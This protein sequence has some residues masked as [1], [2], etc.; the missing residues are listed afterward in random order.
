MA[1]L[2][3][4]LMT[5]QPV[6]DKKARTRAQI[7]QAALACFADKGYHQTSMDDIV[8]KSGLSKGALYWHFKSKQELFLSLIE[9]YMS[10]YGEE[11]SHAWS[12]E[13]P[14]ADKIQALMKF[15][16]DTSEQLIPFFRITIDFWAQTSEDE[17][18]RAIFDEMLT[19]F[20]QQLGALIEE[21]VAKG[22]FRPVESR[23]LALALIAALDALALYK[24]LLADKID[25]QGSAETL[26]EMVI[27]GLK[28]Q[29]ANNVP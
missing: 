7:L 12:D 23:Q 25:I 13:M 1:N 6:G 24:T 3:N 14:A 17:Q 5:H 4:L 16:V 8:A 26:L 22:E 28:P 29:G 10:A 11:A 27:A 2:E 18:L 19:A 15:F 20:Q 21:G 9:T